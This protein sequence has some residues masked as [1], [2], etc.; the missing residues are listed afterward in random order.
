MSFV[1]EC[2]VN[3]LTAAKEKHPGPDLLDR[4]LRHGCNMEVQVNV[5]AGN[6]EPVAGK[7][8]TFT[9]GLNE[10]WNLRIPKESMA[11]EEAAS[12][13]DYHLTWPLELHAEGI[14]C[15]GWDWKHGCSRWVGFDF[16][17]IIG[18]AKGVGIS[19]E[20]LEEVKR[21]ASSLDYVETRKSTGGKGLHLYIPID[22]IPTENHTE[23]AALARCILSM[24]GDQAGF[25]FAA[26]IDCCGGVMWIWNVRANE[27]TEGLKLLK[28]ATKMIGI[29]DLPP[30]WRDHIDVVSRKRTKVKVDGINGKDQDIFDALTAA[31]PVTK[32][33]DTHKAII[34][35]LATSGFST[36]WISDY[37]LCQTHTAALKQM[38]E[39][40]QVCIELG[41]KGVF[42][43]TSGGTDR[44]TPNCFMFPVP[45]GGWKVYRFGPGVSEHE[46]WDQDGEGWTT[47]WF[48][49]TPN[50]KSAAKSLG[51]A[52]LDKKKGF[53]FG[54]AKKAAEA[55]KMLGEEITLP[56]DL[57]GKGAELKANDDGRV[58][59]RIKVD[60]EDKKPDSSWA[61]TPGG[62][63]Q[64]VFEA[65]VDADEDKVDSSEFDD[66][67]RHL[68][69]PGCK[70][71]A[72]W[73]IRTTK[74]K[75]TAHNNTSAKMVL[76]TYG[77]AKSD[78]EVAMGGAIIEPWELDCK[79]FS[80]EF[81]GQRVWNL[82]APQWAVDKADIKEGE[83]PHH[84]HWDRIL[85]HCFADLTGDIQA[86]PW[87]GN[88]GI[89][90]GREYGLAWI[91]AMFQ[92]PAESL[93]FLFFYGNQNCGKSIFHE[94]ISMLMTTGV[95]D[96][97]KPLMTR[98]DFNGE[99]AGGV[100][101][102]IEEVDINV[103]PQAYNR[104][105]EW[106]TSKIIW[107][108]R[109][110][111]DSYPA[112]NYLH[113]CMMSNMPSACPVL[114]GD[115]RITVIE[116]ADL[117][118][119][120]P[121]EI[122][123]EELRREA[124]H[125]RWTLEN[126]ELPPLI[127]RLRLPVVETD[128]KRE[129]QNASNDELNFFLEECCHYAPGEKLEFTKF[130]EKFISWIDPVRRA[131]WSKGQV[132]NAMPTNFPYGKGSGNV[133]YVGNITFDAE[134]AK[135]CKKKPPLIVIKG[136]IKTQGEEE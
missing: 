40:Q 13:K 92:K 86:N 51:A 135:T 80:D 46:T 68:V 21:Q 27:E 72:G 112:I 118:E 48:N 133:R 12:F 77:C 75:W 90:S 22:A 54:S 87:F 66:R 44:A 20:A 79:P 134:L 69:S 73:M 123:H 130:Y 26:Q 28:P 41:L 24:M 96:A 88:H 98:G 57:S 82:N 83:K 42:D 70:N 8:S 129:V 120:I 93:P 3:F 19:D 63:I 4:F 62:W 116:V 110:R 119:D 33:D 15:T 45:N 101:A 36:V 38:M 47:C 81:P 76:Q 39:D 65:K 99:L 25:D 111:M 9:D 94:A 89:N 113:F 55:I 128:R 71:S 108:R 132:G 17:A 117:T 1:T 5:A 53:Q 60:K 126:F 74:G 127:G 97:K 84:P 107:I 78:A 11:S 125:F 7:K 10:W 67:V 30:N 6:G 131:A 85:Q 18:H 61:D 37:S 64:K 43:T 32:L 102:V 95:V 49:R 23:H 121:R 34:D 100:L 103:N 109:M 136:R 52:E 106:V 50:L 124:S 56:E 114:P 2:I 31:R 58:V 14:G 104:L 122:L 91:A 115:S 59:M 29:D 35:E 105:K 16:D